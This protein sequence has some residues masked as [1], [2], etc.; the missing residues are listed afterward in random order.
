MRPAFRVALALLA[1]TSAT[2]AQAADFDGSRPL[3]CATMQ[4]L[5]CAAGQEQCLR[6]LPGEMGAPTFMRIDFERKAIIGPQRTS[7]VMHMEKSAGQVL[8]Q[9]QE[10]G[11]GWTIALDQESGQ[12]TVTLADRT[13]AIVLFGACTPQ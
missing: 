7:Q 2:L 1:G 12:M 11:F 8:L 5:D 9:G 10:L 13:G 3:I 4:A 6:G